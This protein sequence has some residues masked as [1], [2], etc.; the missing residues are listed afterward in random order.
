MQAIYAVSENHVIGYEK[1]GKHHLP[2]HIKDDLAFF[3]QMTSGKVVIMGKKTFESLGCKPLPNRVN[4]VVTRKPDYSKNT[5]SLFFATLEEVEAMWASVEDDS[6]MWVIGGSEIFNLLAH[7]IKTVYVTHVE[8]VIDMPQMTFM[9]DF[10][11]K[12]KQQKAITEGEDSY[13]YRIVR[14][15]IDK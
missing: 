8:V 1:D 3:K 2:W 13:K 9:H 14:Y 11:L 5:E 10:L 4:V 15:S 6:N 12:G 7:H